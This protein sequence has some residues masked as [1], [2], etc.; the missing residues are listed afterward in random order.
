MKQ[1][2]ITVPLQEKPQDV[3]EDI[4]EDD[5]YSEDM[6]EEIEDDEVPRQEFKFGNF[7]KPESNTKLE[8]VKVVEEVIM[9]E[10]SAAAESPV[11]QKTT[12]EEKGNAPSEQ[13]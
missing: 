12:K 9:E 2:E 3:I 8:P 13:A 7:K 1:K 10:Q 11:K 4:P 5:E 6:E